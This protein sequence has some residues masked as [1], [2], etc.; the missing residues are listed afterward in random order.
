MA[1]P[2]SRASRGRRC[3]GSGVRRAGSWRCGIA[4]VCR[5]LVRAPHTAHPRLNPL[6]F[7]PIHL[8]GDS[9]YHRLERASSVNGALAAAVYSAL[10]FAIIAS[11]YWSFSPGSWSVERLTTP[12]GLRR[13]AAIC[14]AVSR[15]S[16]RVGQSCSA[17]RAPRRRRAANGGAR[18]P[19]RREARTGSTRKTTLSRSRAAWVRPR[20]EGVPRCPLPLTACRPLLP[21]P[22][23]AWA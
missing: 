16:T 11:L 2:P 9:G 22:G 10:S 4:I 7:R 20:T 18:S 3:P 14:A 6:L 5:N 15:R 1:R 8:R 19:A 13:S 12:P 21:R 23:A 17:M